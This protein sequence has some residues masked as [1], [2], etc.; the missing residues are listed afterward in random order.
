MCEG[1]GAKISHRLGFNSFLVSCSRGG[2]RS[3]TASAGLDILRQNEMGA[4]KVSRCAA[5]GHHISLLLLLDRTPSE[6]R[7]LPTCRSSLAAASASPASKTLGS[8]IPQPATLLRVSQMAS[9]AAPISPSQELLQ[10]KLL[11][12]R[13]RL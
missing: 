2:H 1:A 9:M 13:P 7:G 4:S 10:V 11:F 3:H 8:K 5:S 12:E 6:A